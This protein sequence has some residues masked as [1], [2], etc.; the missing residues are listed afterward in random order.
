MSPEAAPAAAAKLL[1]SSIALVLANLVPLAGV[2]FFGWGVFPLM[3]LFWL[4]NV[5]VGVLNVVKMLL[6]SPDRGK[7]WAVKMFLVPFF[8]VHYGMFCLVH[9]V[10]VLVL[11]RGP[12]PGGDLPGPEQIAELIS[13]WNLGWAAL[14]LLAS[15]GFSLVSNYLLTGRFRHTNPSDLMKAPY[16]RIVVLHVA[17]LGGGFLLTALNSPIW[18]LVLLI[19]GKVL[20]DLNAH[21]R[22]HAGPRRAFNPA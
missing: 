15:H 18:G 19:I 11:F 17:I 1:P 8:T 22:E 6:A 16:G 14:A 13:R 9:G 12:R 2:L 4:E 21:R 20:L 10:F 3:L 5:I 7:Y